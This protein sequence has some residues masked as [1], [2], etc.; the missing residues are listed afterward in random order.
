MAQGVWVLEEQ[1]ALRRA[2]EESEENRLTALRSAV[3]AHPRYRPIVEYVVRELLRRKPADA[4][5][6]AR[7]YIERWRVE[8]GQS[9]DS[10]ARDVLAFAMP[11]LLPPAPAM[12][13]PSP[14]PT[15]ATPGPGPQ[16]IDSFEIGYLIDAS[17]SQYLYAATKSHE[18]G[19]TEWHF[20]RWLPH[21]DSA[22]ARARLEAHQ[23]MPAPILSQ[24]TTKKALGG[25]Q[26][27]FY[28]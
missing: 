5:V 18:G 16:T 15:E 19:I 14:P 13:P 2:F 7:R 25:E 17:S 9:P 1:V 20:A 3:K 21:L 22:T 26:V 23:S 10:L 28:R 27:A 8:T 24:R 11:E 4:D 12:T 6:E